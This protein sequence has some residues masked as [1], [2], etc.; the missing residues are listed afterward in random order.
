MMMPAATIAAMALAKPKLRVML[1]P[2]ASQARK[3]TAP[4]AVLPTENAERLAC[5]RGKAQGKIFQGL[6]AHPLVILAPLPY[7]ALRNTHNSLSGTA[8]SLVKGN[9]RGGLRYLSP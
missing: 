3:D 5:L 7:D 2:I 8:I 6:V 4:I 1:P 9:L